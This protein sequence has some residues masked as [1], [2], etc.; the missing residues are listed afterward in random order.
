MKYTIH[1]TDLADANIRSIILNIAQNFGNETALKK[2]DEIEREIRV[3]E[4]N[5][6]IGIEPR[7][8]VLKHQGYRILILEKNL[9][10]YKVD[11]GRKSVIIYAVLDQRRD[12]I[13]ILRGL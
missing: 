11:E 4:S 1:K 12:Y 9:A 7:Y 3:L 8:L 13:N 2:L 10:F 5:P 6:Y